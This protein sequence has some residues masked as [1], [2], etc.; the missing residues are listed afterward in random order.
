MKQSKIGLHHAMSQES[1]RKNSGSSLLPLSFLKSVARAAFV[2]S[3]LVLGFGSVQQARAAGYEK[4]IMWGARSAGI[5]GIATPYIQGSEALYFNPAGLVSDKVGQDVSFNISPTWSQFKGPINNRNDVATSSTSTSFPFGLAYGMTLNEK[6]GF[7]V[8]GYISGGSKAIYDNVSFSDYAFQPQVK[9]DLTIAELAA[10][11]G[12]RVD[13]N[14]K[15]GLAYRVILANASFSTIT[16]SVANGPI[17]NT[18]LADLKDTEFTGFKLGAQYKLGEKTLLGFSYRSEVNLKAKGSINATLAQS[19]A[20]GG[21]TTPVST[22]GATA[23]TTFPMAAT[24]GLQEDCTEQWRFLLE[25]VWTNYSR[26]REIAIDGTVGPNPIPAVEQDWFDQHNFRFGGE[27][28]GMSWPVRFGYVMTTQVTNATRARAAFE[29]PGLGHTLTLGTG[30]VWT[31]MERPLQFDVAGE[32]SMVS[33]KGKGSDAGANTN[34]DDIRSGSY[35]TS[36]YVAHLGVS[37][38]F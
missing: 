31:M 10:G 3:I 32:Y 11:V 14:L 23:S 35:T 27:Y 5:G 7:G 20:L 34:A 29:A 2:A 15:V 28:K 37:Y 30:H 12:Y 26:V 21:G 9:S 25:Y 19:N 13:E 17:I 38:A 8:G 24:I 18:T 22:T 16:R 36:A 6:W 1:Y 33:G 4:S